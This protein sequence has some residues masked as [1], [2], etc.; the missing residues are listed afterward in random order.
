M[1]GGPE[2]NQ[3]NTRDGDKCDGSSGKY[4]SDKSLERLLVR[5]LDGS[6]MIKGSTIEIVATMWAWSDGSEDYLDLY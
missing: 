4:Q 6:V 3:P 2:E 1:I 5:S